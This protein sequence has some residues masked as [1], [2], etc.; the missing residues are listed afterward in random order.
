MTRAIYYEDERGRKPAKEWVNDVK[1]ASIKPIIR[2]RIE[3]LEEGQLDSLI[4][5]EIVEIIRCKANIKG[6]YELKHKRPTGW[7]LAFYHDKSNDKYV[8][9]CGF[10]KQKDSQKGDIALACKFAMDYIENKGK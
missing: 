8:L 1:N 3:T 9:L 5:R 10:R 2:K 6:L 7:R 4:E